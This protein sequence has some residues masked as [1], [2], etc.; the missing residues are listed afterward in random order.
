MPKEIK[1]KMKY[2]KLKYYLKRKLKNGD[3]ALIPVVDDPPEENKQE[4]DNL[5]KYKSLKAELLEKTINK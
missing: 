3:I 2:P 1:E 5:I 4:L